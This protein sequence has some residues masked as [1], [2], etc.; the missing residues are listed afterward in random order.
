VKLTW[1]ERENLILDLEETRRR[2]NDVEH[3]PMDRVVNVH[4]WLAYQD[5]LRDVISALERELEEE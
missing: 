2:L 3:A 1:I 4:R 5:D